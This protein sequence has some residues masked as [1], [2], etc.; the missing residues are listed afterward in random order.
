MY[1]TCQFEIKGVHSNPMPP[2]TADIECV[3]HC[4]TFLFKCKRKLSQVPVSWSAHNFREDCETFIKDYFTDHKYGFF[5]LEQNSCIDLAQLLIDNCDLDYCSVQEM[6]I[7]GI[8]I[9][10]DEQPTEVLYTRQQVN[11]IF[12]PPGL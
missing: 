10:V 7:G 12:G 5:N 11:R 6:G 4:H 3:E 2:L 8:E 1:E 9:I